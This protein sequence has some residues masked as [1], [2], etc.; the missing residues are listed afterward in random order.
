MGRRPFNRVAEINYPSRI[1]GWLD[2]CGKFNIFTL[3]QDSCDLS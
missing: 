3:T 2:V 1:E